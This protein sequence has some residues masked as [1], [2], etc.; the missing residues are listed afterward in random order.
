MQQRVE[1]SRQEISSSAGMCSNIFLPDSTKLWMNA[2]STI[3]FSMPFL[4][5]NRSIKLNREAFIEVEKYEKSPFIVKSGNTSDE[6]LGIKF[7]LKAYPDEKNIEIA[8][9][10]G[11]VQCNGLQGAQ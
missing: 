6:V 8:L 7:N 1:I 4:S 2:D 11:T 10:E 5:E 9:K 3:C